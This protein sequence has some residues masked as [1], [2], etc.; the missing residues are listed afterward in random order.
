MK[1][2][3]LNGSRK[4][5]D[6]ITACIDMKLS[7]HTEKKFSD[8]EVYVKSNTNVRGED[9]YV[10][11]SLYEDPNHSVGDKIIT[12]YNFVSSLK[13]ASVGRVTVITPY[14]AFSRQ[15]RK[16]ES[17]APIGTKYMARLIETAGADRFMTMD[18]H[19]LSSI[20]NGFR[21]PADNLEAKNLFIDY[22]TDDSRIGNL[23]DNLTIF[24]PDN[25]GMG[26]VRRF[27]TALEKRLGKLN[28]ITVAQL[29][30]ERLN[31]DEVTG[32][33]VLGDIKGRNVIIYDDMIASGKTIN[34]ASEAIR[35][36]EGSVF[37]IC[38]THGLFV[39]K[40]NENLA[41][42][43]NIVVTNTVAPFRMKNHKKLPVISTESMFAEAIKRTHEGGSI[44][45]L[46]E[47]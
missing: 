23:P 13:D 26:R 25:G 32:D 40:A 43:N 45:E 16:T 42:V 37:A 14:F 36:H 17:R 8:G 18:I 35:L 39:G 20:Q 5:A 21:I 11:S 1:I 15:D 12:L 44:S 34:I 28:T 22:F 24:S 46:L 29:D 6:R 41:D 47:S 33:E 31:G 3:G 7:D 10:I 27:R 38:A 30:K 19:N 4:F 9:V 2:F